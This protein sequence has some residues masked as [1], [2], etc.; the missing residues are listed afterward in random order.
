MAKKGGRIK[1]QVANKTVFPASERAWAER[2]YTVHSVKNLRRDN[3][4]IQ[5]LAPVFIVVAIINIIN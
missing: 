3:F 2:D 4:K 5:P 1:N